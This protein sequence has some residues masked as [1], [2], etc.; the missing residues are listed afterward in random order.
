M[1]TKWTRRKSAWIHAD[2][3]AV[4]ARLLKRAEIEGRS[5]DTESVVRHRLDVYAEQTAPIAG[6]Y[7]SHDLLVQV[8]GIGAVE[9]VT[10]RLLA[11]IAPY[12]A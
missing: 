12:V 11:A 2:A 8:D 3:A 4:V 7:A 10:A 5:D 9:A 1:P 6:V